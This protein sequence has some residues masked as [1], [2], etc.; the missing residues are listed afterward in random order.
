[1][2]N[3]NIPEDIKRRVRQEC[4]F[5][6]ALCGMPI[7]EYDHIEEYSKVK[8]HEVDNIIL[9]CP[10]H[11]G[12]KNQI[13]I[14]RIREARIN[15][16]NNNRKTISGYKLEPNRTVDIE[17]GSNK[18]DKQFIENGDYH[19]LWI[20]GKSFFAVHNCDGWLTLSFSLTDDNGKLLLSVDRG[21]L[22]FSSE[23]WD[24]EYKGSRLKL[25]SALRQIL[26]DMTLTNYFV[27]ILRG[28]FIHN[29]SKDG[30]IIKPDG[31]LSVIIDG[32]SRSSAN[33]CKYMDNGYGGIGLLNRDRY[34]NI[35]RPIGFGWFIY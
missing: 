34:P 33:G 25:K 9:L 35:E 2:Q 28:S 32:C 8:K 5:G 17:I 14:S 21:E 22:Q 15:P 12:K 18:I 4:N 10:N 23:I 3:R 1:M 6:C 11:H 30:L 27:Q 7:F 16:Y 19:C 20:N 24:Y 31:S 29:E 26:L 13:D